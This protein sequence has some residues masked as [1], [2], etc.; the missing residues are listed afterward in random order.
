M[1]ARQIAI[2]AGL[3]LAPAAGLG[4]GRFAFALLVPALRADLHWTYADAGAVN[5]ANGAGYLLGAACAGALERRLGAKRTVVASLVVVALALG[6]S[7]LAA[8]TPPLVALRFV[9]GVAA[10]TAFVAGGT[11]AAGVARDHVGAARALG[12]YVSGGGLG[13]VVSA[14]VV[15]P[16]LASA[17]LR[18]GWLALAAAALVML[19]GAALAARAARV[20]ARP[21]ERA[22]GAA[23]RASLRTLRPTM[24]AYG[25]YGAG[26]IAY[27]TFI[28]AYL[29]AHEGFTPS[30]VTAFWLVL[31]GTTIAASFAWPQVF[32]RVRGG[33]GVSA[34]LA[35]V[36]VG[37]ALPVVVPTPAG[38]FASALVFGG[39]FLAVVAS[40]TT[41]A[42]RRLPPHAWSGAIGALTTAFA[43]GQALGPL[44]TGALSDGPR[45][46]SVG[47]LASAGVLALA[48]ACALADREEA[49]RAA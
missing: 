3:A 20:P 17:G 24:L 38:A 22:G 7:G 32:A 44:A 28:V 48:A 5:A 13:I 6:G 42:R 49:P 9:V 12:L 14:L 19:L 30:G 16:L 43:A 11:L 26:Y 1:T 8:G 23:E 4:L 41:L 47:L 21:P 34:A 36:T 25:L 31:G 10:A 2:A 39:S 15:P 18:G 37:A 29:V 46:L 45:G 27:M 33:R 40:V 35:C